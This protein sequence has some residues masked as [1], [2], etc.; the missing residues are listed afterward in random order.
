MG[1][2]SSAFI[3]ITGRAWADKAAADSTAAAIRDNT[4]MQHSIEKKSLRD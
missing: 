2:R 4:R 1:I 3:S